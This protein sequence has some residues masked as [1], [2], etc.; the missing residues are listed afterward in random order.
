MERPERNSI[1]IFQIGSPAIVIDCQNF[2]HFLL[3]ASQIDVR[4]L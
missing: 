4:T 1:D 3:V 2:F